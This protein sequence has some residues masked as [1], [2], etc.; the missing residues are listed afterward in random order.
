[1]HPN[2]ISQVSQDSPRRLD[3][4]ASVAQAPTDKPFELANKGSVF[5][6]MLDLVEARVYAQL[7]ADFFASHGCPAPVFVVRGPTS[8]TH[9]PFEVVDACCGYT[10]L[11]RAT[12]EPRTTD[13][14]AN[15]TLS[16]RSDAPDRT[17]EPVPVPASAPR[18]RPKA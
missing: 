10:V 17:P 5:R 9:R 2:P 18:R 13:G 15:P 14:Q 3:P 1:M 6:G 12:P 8:T 16:N 11:H 7:V 4:W